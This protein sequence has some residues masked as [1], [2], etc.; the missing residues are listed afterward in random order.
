VSGDTSGAVDAVLAEVR[1]RIER[2]GP[3]EAARIQSHGGL[4]IDIRPSEQRADEGV[5]PGALVIDRNVLE[6]RLDP[7][8]PH[9][10]PD[11]GP[12]GR[13]LVVF[14]QAGYASSFAVEAL[15]RLGVERISDLAGGFAAWRSAGLPVGLIPQP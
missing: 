3:A 9:R 1:T 2:V 7:T 4:L 14:C 12:P 11:A 13:E 15:V 10:H 5:I 6:W 8:G